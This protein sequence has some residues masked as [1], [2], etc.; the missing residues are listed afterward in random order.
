MYG[1]RDLR[2]YSN[3]YLDVY[4]SI[5]CFLF[6]FNFVL[7]KYNI[8]YTIIKIPYSANVYVVICINTC[9]YCREM[10]KF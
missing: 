3:M 9:R 7:V 4:F 8:K 5:L 2:V 1:A 10:L 6:I